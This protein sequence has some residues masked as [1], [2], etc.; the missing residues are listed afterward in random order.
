MLLPIL[1]KM[2]VGT[3]KITHN[4]PFKGSNCSTAM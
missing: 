1:L 3:V 2:S 4:E